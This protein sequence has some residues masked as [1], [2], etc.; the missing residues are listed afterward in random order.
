MLMFEVTQ[1][2]GIRS[3]GEG[4]SERESLESLESLRSKGSGKIRSDRQE[5]TSTKAQ[6]GL[7]FGMFRPS[8]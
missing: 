4:F 1:R 8:F 5:M 6:S 3:A 7:S 2:P